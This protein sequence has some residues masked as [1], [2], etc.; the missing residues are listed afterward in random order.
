MLNILDEASQIRAYSRE[1]ERKSSELEAAGRELKVANEQLKELDRIK[2]DFM[3][4]VTHELRTPLASIRAFSEILADDPEI[5]LQQRKKFLDIIVIETERLTRL[6]NQVLD[7]AKIES[8]HANWR[9]EQVDLGELIGVGCEVNARLFSERGVRLIV[10]LPEV[11]CTVSA[12]RDRLMQVLVNLLS[13][14]AKFAPANTGEV[15][16]RLCRDGEIFRISVQD[17][18]PGVAV[19]DQQDI[20]EKF[21]QGS[22]S[23]KPVGTGLGLPISRR[24]IEHFGGRIQVESRPGYGATFTFELPA[25]DSA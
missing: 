10:E 1:L 13:N 20:F 3:S 22:S 23:E 4:S 14:A 8:G 5:E 18:G 7:L 9:I 17:N 15:C 12:D 24:I 25:M 11:T 16:V 19:E 2:D 6:V 21:R